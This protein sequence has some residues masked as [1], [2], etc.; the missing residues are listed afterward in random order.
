[1]KDF[2]WG[3]S[4]AAF[5]IEGDDG[6]QGRG[7][8]VW[9]SY[10]EREGVI[11]NGDNAKITCNHYE[12]YREDIALMADL[13]INS[14]RFSTSWSRIFPEGIGKSNPKGVDFYDKLIDG[15]LEK[16]IQPFLT[17]YH[18]D[19]PQALSDRGGFQNPDF[20]SWFA[21]YADFIASRYGDRVKSYCTF[22]EPINAISSSYY[23]GVFAPGYR[24]NEEQAL[25]CMH[26]MHL[27]HVRAGKILREKNAHVGV[28]MST[29]EEYPA[30]LTDRCI[31]VAK[32]QFFKRDC[33]LESID[34]Y[35]DPIYLGYYPKWV[36]ARFPDFAE[37]TALTREELKD[38]VST[39][40]G[41]N[42]YSGRP[43]LENGQEM[44]RPLGV[45]KSVLG[46]ILDSNG[47]YW[48]TK[49]LTERYKLPLYVLE[50]GIA[51][52]DW[53][54]KD[55]GVH[56]TGR[57]DF[58]RQSLEVI[59]RLRKEQVDIRGYFVWSLLD[60]FEWLRGYSCRFGLIHTD[61]ESLKRTP[62]DSYYFYRDYIKNIGEKV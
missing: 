12:K 31:D 43:I 41:Y 17:L 3:V 7:K 29:F 36:L 30:V 59:E 32:A 50:N 47:L 58:L 46:S 57:I 42:T 18:W 55:G 34:A 48:G 23:A 39:Y 1:M 9:D 52:A 53:V 51:C 5:Q 2:L 20:P 4:T 8:S 14:Y 61:Y 56:D 62:K 16:N 49:F 24:L 27:A 11:E 15:L 28:A 38:V 13:G 40:V 10:C 21:E 44:Q 25:W 26:H 33:A 60:N 45:A 37:K 22:N 54:E 35:M 19:L 6:K